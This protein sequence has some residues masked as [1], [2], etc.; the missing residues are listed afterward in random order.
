MI[1]ISERIIEK[2]SLGMMEE[3]QSANKK[4]ISN[5]T[6]SLPK[7]GGAI[8]GIGETFQP[9]GFSG[10]G[11]FSIA[12]P[13]TSARDSGWTLSL[14]YHSG[15]GNG[16]FGMGFSLSQPKISIRTEKGIPR[17]DGTETY[18][19][20]SGELVPKQKEHY[21]DDQGWDVY[22]FMPRIESSF[23]QIERHIKE[24]QSESYWKI[25]N[26]KNETSFWGQTN[27]SRVFNPDNASQI[28]EWLLDRSVDSKGN[29]R[30]YLYKAE[31]A[32]GLSNEIWEQGRSFNNKYLQSIK[33]GNYIDARN[34]EQF[35]FQVVFDYGE[36]DLSDLNQGGQNPYQPLNV[37]KSRPDSFSSYLSGFEIRTC[38]LCYHILLFHCLENELGAPCLVKSI[39]LEYKQCFFYGDIRM[40]GLSSIQQVILTGYK[41]KGEKATDPYETQQK[42]ALQLGFS[43]FKSPESS[44]FKNLEIKD[45]LIPE[46][47]RSFGF[48]F[49]DMNLE[50]ISGLLYQAG[51]ATFYCEP[52][53]EGQY[54]MPAAPNRF[55]MD[56]GYDDGRISLVDLES[57]GEL[58]WV[59]KESNRAGFYRKEAD[60]SWGNFQ[61]FE[62]YPT[63]FSNSKLETAGLNNNG[64]ADLLLVDENKILVYPSMGKE[65]YAAP[66]SHLSPIDFPLLNKGNRKEWVGFANMLGDG[67][68]HRIKITNGCVDCWPDLG[69]GKFG[70]KISLGKAP[71]FG[72]DFDVSRLFL[73]D[74]DGSGTVDILY[75]HPD[76]VDL[77]INMSGNFFSDAITV[78]LPESYSAIDQISFSDVLGN[79]TTC[80]VFTKMEP[81]VKHYYYDFVGEITVGGMKYKSMKP[82]LLNVIDNNLG[83]V[84]QIQYCSSTKFYLEDRKTGHPWMTKLPFPVQLIEK[85]IVLD[86][87]TG[88]RYTH[89]F[90]YHDGYYDSVEREFRGFGL[91]EAWDTEAYQA[92]QK[93]SQNL[94]YSI[95]LFEK[96]NYVPPV[97]TKTWYHT[98]ICLDGFSVSNQYKDH[99]FKGDPKAYDF[100]DS[101]FEPTIYLEDAETIRQ[102]YVALSGRVIRTEI[103]AE[104]AD[105]CPEKAPN[106]YTVEESA[107]EVTLYQKRGKGGYAVFMV[108][109]RESISY[110]Y[111]REPEDPR[112]QQTFTLETDTFGN[113]LQ[114][115][116]VFLPRRSPSGLDVLIYPEQQELKSTLQLS[117]YIHC[118]PEAI[119]CHVACE[120]QGFELFGLDLK[121]NPYF[122][123]DEI[124]TQVCLALQNTVPYDGVLLSGSLQ[125]RQVTWSK[126]YFWNEPQTAAL[127]F[128]YIS[129]KALPHHDEEAVF[130]E[131]FVAQVF[132]GRITDETIQSEGG[133]FF[134]TASSYWWNKG[135]VQHYFLPETPHRFYRACKT[136]NSFVDSLSSLFS[137]TI[138][139]Y[140]SY[141]LTPIQVSQILDDERSNVVRAEI[142]Y[143]TFQPKQI[144]DMNNNITQALFDP[145]GQVIV[146]SLFGTEKGVRTGGMT[147]YPD[148]QVAAEYILPQ[149]SS[150]QDVIDHPEV[151]LQGTSNYFYYH[152]NAWT[153]NKQPACFMN[154]I[155]NHYW[156]SSDQEELPYCQILIHYA[157]GIGR[158]L[159]SK[160]KVD[161][162]MA[163]IRAENGALVLGKNQYP[164]P[165]STDNR[166][167]VSGRTVY[168]N[169]GKPF[170][171]YLP[172]FVNTPEYEDQKDIPCPPPT[173]THYDP[174]ER[175]IRVDTPKGFFSKVEFT[176]WNETHYDEDDTV[177]DSSY[178]QLN[179]PDHL[180]ADQ[181]DAIDKS[182]VF[183]N[184]PRIRVL[185]N[186]GGMF[187]DIQNNLGDVSKKAFV[188]IVKGT[189]VS[190]EDVW[191]ELKSRGYLVEDKINPSFTWL[192]PTFQPYVKGFELELGDAFNLFAIPVVQLLKQ[193]MLTSYFSTDISGRNTV[194]IDPRLYYSNQSQGTCYYNFKYRYMMGKETPVLVDST[195]AGTEKHLSNM[196]ESQMWSWSARDYCQFITY[197]R[198]QRQI[199]LRVKKINDSGPVISYDDFNL[200]EVFT[201]GETLTD[202]Q[203]RNLKGL[204][205]ELKDLSGVTV[206]SQ[207]SMQG[208]VLEAS[209]QLVKD[210]KTAANWNAPVVLEE[211]LFIMVSSYNAIKQLLCERTPDGSVTTNTYNQAGQ[212]IHVRLDFTDENSQQVINQIEYDA[213][214]QRITIEYGNNVVTT[215]SYE[216]TTLRLT[217]MVSTRPAD[218]SEI[219]H[220]EYYYDPVGNITRT[221]DNTINDVYCNNQKVEP[222]FNYTYDAIYRLIQA[223]G[224]QHQGIVANTYKNNTSD[225]SFKQSI[226]G[227]PPSVNDAGKLENY[228]EIF[229]YDDSGNLIK[230][231]HTAVS[232]SWTKETAIEDHSNRLKDLE[233]DASGNLRML[234]LNNSV[235]LSYNCCENLIKVGIIE[236]PDELDDCDYYLYD[237][238][239]QR[240]RK[241]SERMA[242][243]GDVTLIEDKMYLGSYQ[244]KRNYS[245]STEQ[246]ANLKFERQTRRVMDDKTCVA[247][248]HFITTDT[249][250]PEKERTRQ[251]RFQMGNNLG[252]VSLELD[253]DAQLISYEEYFPY[254][255][256]A[257]I[258]GINQS[259]VNLKDY[260]YSGKECDDSTGLYYYGARYYITWLGRWN[261]PDPA[262]TVDG[263]NLYAF[264]GGNPI[265]H[266]DRKGLCKRNPLGVFMTKAER[267]R[268]APEVRS[269]I[270]D[271]FKD[272]FM[273]TKKI[274]SAHLYAGKLSVVVPP[275][276][277]SPE[278]LLVRHLSTALL[279]QDSGMIEVQAAINHKDQ[280]IYVASNNNQKILSGLLS[281]TLSGLT[282]PNAALYSGREARHIGKLSYE[283]AGPF[284]DY[285][286]MQVF[287][288]EDVHAEV[289]IESSGAHYDYIGG[290][291]RPCFA[292]SMYFQQ[293][294]T[295]PSKYNPHPGAYWDSQAAL[296]PLV[297]FVPTMN[298]T[299]FAGNFYQTQ[300]L[301]KSTVYDYD[302]DSEAE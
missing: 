133:Y 72:Q 28:F 256:T 213:K 242:H 8:T 43:A 162:G 83:A 86:Q 243:G 149:S 216:E 182:I 94:E 93:N 297:P 199:G 238:Q 82:Y 50:G 87:I 156:Q 279:V 252:S 169:K 51:D 101:V 175:K 217:L 193:N 177:L 167:Q 63:D 111:E 255:G 218:A 275:I 173:V 215:Y 266:M 259:E 73:A 273:L 264:V 221:R 159:E 59:V 69:Y 10:T 68:S 95:S 246:P 134:D 91:V 116:S 20:D 113:V 39:D 282:L 222:L 44:E 231:Q 172:Y 158:K 228:S 200:V 204:L 277:M 272:K 66:K 188:D 281:P 230:K 227:P 34:Q 176:P 224:R 234:E 118:L 157:D 117:S 35:A 21:K 54:A 280:M 263:M 124:G 55:P 88:C 125:A 6:I 25:I 244:I 126:S 19:F 58:E 17:Y 45:S 170:E 258:T 254:G 62:S 271:L 57:R 103:Y 60:G 97:H 110:Q 38:R 18:T 146:T 14:N 114:L 96:E 102:A 120:E 23:S 161:P 232:A 40:T 151:Y 90:K 187:L 106:P 71:C 79:G 166:W 16:P 261:K 212:L 235:N 7:G 109:P 141:F 160:T 9:N 65:G 12:I 196:Y 67:L 150:F 153:E 140:D 74:V 206:N 247:I 276:K 241:V 1:L 47:V 233:Q 236:R 185:D 208:Q 89:S 219:Q 75:A 143:R 267:S 181:R 260:R 194:L 225:G 48:Q 70:S 197:D 31:N 302:T 32:D 183:Y 289:K 184:T 137:Q 171:E 223:D 148:G 265:S 132:D 119:Y 53:G 56:R 130:T 286:L 46:N 164:L 262:G 2:N 237:S 269:K 292:C 287:G 198:L 270:T 123:F 129:A 52:E 245:G 80:L 239:E 42:P 15:A 226:Y 131:D 220:I 37:W 121:N 144:L 98:G 107:V 24:D 92:F 84:T 249:Q 112:I 77:F 253:K 33:Y 209:R 100:P 99:Y 152:L 81:V 207:Y 13:V 11:S 5:P 155:R 165:E 189:A 180:N 108:I 201:Y 301:P 190:S 22:E 251:C 211:E 288:W 186:T 36:Y 299:T 154:L 61:S 283:M 174:L 285:R 26:D 284:K 195:D 240:T 105:E 78:Y 85:T 168:N 145:L 268:K 115:C 293:M 138:L 229:T 274:H 76:R 296:L 29:Q 202:A 49:V 294:K 139:E 27:D 135:L 278:R 41:R 290:T 192:S 298:T 136:E 127:P 147:L 205:Y 210:Y 179:Y 295:D 163:F 250:N 3:K 178:Y 257:I 300:G 142:D 248:I 203:D 214:G 30:V 191:N 128:G 104:D 4:T 291:R 64:K 122:N